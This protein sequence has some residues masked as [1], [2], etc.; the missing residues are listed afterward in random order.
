MYVHEYHVKP[1][2]LLVSTKLVIHT[3]LALSL[4]RSPGLMRSIMVS[5]QS[6]HTV[7]TV[8]GLEEMFVAASDGL[9]C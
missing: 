7:T 9:W 5:L 6:S 2:D 1:L 3:F 8:P 4:A